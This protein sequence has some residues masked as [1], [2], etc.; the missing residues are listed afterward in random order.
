MTLCG[1]YREHSS[2]LT[3]LVHIFIQFF[4]TTTLNDIHRNFEQSRKLNDEKKLRRQDQF[5]DDMLD[6][7]DEYEGG[8]VTG[9]ME[10]K[11][12]TNG[13]TNS[14][15][16]SRDFTFF[17]RHDPLRWKDKAN[18]LIQFSAIFATARNSWKQNR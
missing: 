2:E 3:I 15:D 17:V 10:E 13:G 16:V 9:F 18:P 4:R 11:P 14:F 12:L 5:I 8:D 6:Y 1:A 7:K